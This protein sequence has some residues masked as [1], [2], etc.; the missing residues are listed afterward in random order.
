MGQAYSAQEFENIIVLTNADGSILRL[1]DI[2]SV[3]DGFVEEEFYAFLT[4]S[5]V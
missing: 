4:A 2:A 3:S 5:R 1:G